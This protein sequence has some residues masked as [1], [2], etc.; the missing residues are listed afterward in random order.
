MT[1]SIANNANDQVVKTF[2]LVQIDFEET[3]YWTDCDIPIVTTGGEGDA[4]AARWEPTG[5]KVSGITTRQSDSNLASIEIQNADNFMSAI[6]FSTSSPVGAR[7]R[8]YEAWFDPTKTS[9]IP[10]DTKLLLDG[11]CG[12]PEL[13]RSGDTATATLR[14]LRGLLGSRVI[15]RRKVV[16]LCMFDFKGSVGCQYAGAATEC[17]RTK[18]TCTS[19][20]NQA[21]FGGFPWNN[22]A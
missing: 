17:D 9:A 15:P 14:A 20:G 8:V 22:G 5:I 3:V 21:R 4:P 10:D 16:D 2:L 12:G 19:L 7:A 6:M 1:Y 18:A 13:S 11:L